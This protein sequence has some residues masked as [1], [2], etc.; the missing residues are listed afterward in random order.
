MNNSISITKLLL[1]LAT[2]LMLCGCI[3]SDP[4][5]LQQQPQKQTYQQRAE[6]ERRL[7]NIKPVSLSSH[8]DEVVC[9]TATTGSA[10]EWE[11][12]EGD[13]RK[14]IAEAKRRGLSLNDCKVAL[15]YADKPSITVASISTT[16]PGVSSLA[17]GNMSLQ[18]SDVICR[19]ATVDGGRTWAVGNDYEK[20]YISEAGRR[21]LSLA[22]CRAVL[23]YVENP[24]ISQNGGQA[25]NVPQSTVKQRASSKDASQNAAWLRNIF[26]EYVGKLLSNGVRADVTTSFESDGEYGVVG[27]YVFF[28][29]GGAV[30]G[31]LGD[32]KARGKGKLNCTWV[33][34]Y[35]SGSLNMRFVTSLNEFEGSWGSAGNQPSAYWSGKAIHRAVK[36][37][38]SVAEAAAVEKRRA[39]EERR[40]AAVRAAEDKLRAAEARK[41]AT[42]R[43]RLAELER[44]KQRI[45]T[46]RQK[47]LAD[48]R[49]RLLDPLRNENRN[50]VAV[51]I[52]NRNYSGST[53][54]VDFAHNDADAITSFLVNKL[55]YRVGNIIDLRDATR[56]QI[57]AVFGND[58]TH[59]GKLFDW[60]RQGQS[61]IT[62]YYSGH[63]VPGLKD[64]RPYLLPVDGDANRA[65]ITGF[66]VDVLYENLSKLNAKSV[67][68][69]LDACFSGDSPK[70]M[71]VRSTSGISIS[72]RLPSERSMTVITAAQGDQFASWDET[73]RHGLFTKHLLDALNGMA[74][75][76]KF[77]DE[78]G[79]ISLQEVRAYLNDE[80]TYQAR[81]TW[82][83]RQE[84]SVRGSDNTVLASVVTGKS[85][86]ELL[87]IQAMD[88]TYTVI[89]SANLR[90]APS[91]DAEI[92][93][94]LKADTSINITGRVYGEN[95]YRLSDGSYVFGDLI[96]LAN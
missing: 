43:A 70:G 36:N 24:S 86:D 52:G 4:L 28:E 73:A 68:V 90:V 42:E 18:S 26:G 11:I 9:R 41:A 62:V 85:E 6:M 72:P 1:T 31:R 57:E 88:A 74:D 55:A 83:R 71:L 92:V 35:G 49:D 33:D 32:C 7:A 94:K 67:I 15:G 89:S 54:A 2:V 16:P 76:K 95:W 63:G 81:R 79:R 51:V 14:Y 45:S 38:E 17:A 40:V 22:D 3:Q 47:R 53:P 19:V 84:A 66:P 61:N 13:Y 21:G 56:N 80:M 25:V 30:T 96:Q 60:T 12:N 27:R 91:T 93:G 23:G 48:A 58:K 39:A 29:N 8:S 10:D 59:E 37:E 77:G 69:Y 50:S 34:S 44:R 65:E 75:A 87:S 82:G 20:K 78:N 5:Y 64:K 46:A